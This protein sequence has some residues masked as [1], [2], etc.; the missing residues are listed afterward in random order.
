MA[1]SDDPVFGNKFSSS[2]IAAVPSSHLLRSAFDV[3]TGIMTSGVIPFS[4]ELNLLR[5]NEDIGVH[6]LERSL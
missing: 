5:W 3:L 2:V 1:E 4:E 6:F